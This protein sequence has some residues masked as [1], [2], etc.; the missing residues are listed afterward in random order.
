MYSKGLCCINQ[1]HHNEEM[2]KNVPLTDTLT[3]TISSI[4]NEENTLSTHF[5]NY[6]NKP[7]ET[8]SED[9]VVLTKEN[10]EES[11]LKNENNNAILQYYGTCGITNG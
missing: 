8:D 5:E 9:S 11:D 3:T 6:D 2:C 7:S 10:I 4:K 1:A